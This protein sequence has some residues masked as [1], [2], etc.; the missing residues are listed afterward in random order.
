MN[1]F[2][3]LL[4]IFFIFY[5]NARDL[6]KDYHQKYLKSYANSENYSKSWSKASQVKSSELLDELAIFYCLKNKDSYVSIVW[7]ISLECADKDK[8]PDILKKHGEIIYKKTLTLKHNGPFL[9]I[10][11]AYKFASW[12]GTWEDDFPGIKKKKMYKRFPKN[13]DSFKID[14]YLL[15]FDSLKTAIKAKH[16]VRHL[17]KVGYNSIHVTD[18][19][20]QAISLAKVIFNQNSMAFLNSANVNHLKNIHKKLDRYINF[21]TQYKSGLNFCATATTTKFLL[22]HKNIDKFH[23]VSKEH[24]FKIPSYCIQDKI[25]DSNEIIFD[26]RRYFYFDEAKFQTI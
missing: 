9:L 8:I 12:L 26:P 23:F 16:E 3:Y 1:L 21:A 17:C 13:K 18:N 7:P 25:A 6:F 11:H 4:F 20:E 22:N 10:R 14:V 5:N 2:I 15:K 24:N 19:Q